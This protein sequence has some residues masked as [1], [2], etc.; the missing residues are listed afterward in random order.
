LQGLN[1]YKKSQG[2]YARWLTFFGVMIVG[3]WGCATLAQTLG[4]TNVGVYVQFILP[5][6]I[7]LCLAWV[8][9]KYVV[10]RPKTADFLIAT[11]GEM[12]KV[13]WSSTKEVVG[14]TKVVI[15][16]TFLLAALLFLV[17]FVFVNLFSMIGITG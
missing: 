3:V 11:E 13:S 10:N 6:A 14:S 17:D 16:T 9:F 8:M 1:I 7:L 12:K 2:K 15:V 4:A 5:V